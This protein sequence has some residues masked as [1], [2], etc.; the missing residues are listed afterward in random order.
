MFRQS[1]TATAAALALALL[2][3]GGNDDD[4]DD[5]GQKSRGVCR[6]AASGVRASARCPTGSL[7]SATTRSIRR[8]HRRRWHA[9][10][11]SRS[12]TPYPA[13][14]QQ[15][16][17]DADG[18]SSPRTVATISVWTGSWAFTRT[19]TAFSGSSIRR[20]RPKRPIR[21][22]PVRSA[23]CQA[24]GLEYEDQCAPKGHRPRCVDDDRVSAQ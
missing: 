5:K 9:E 19:P 4:S 23:A 1:R 7:S 8:R 21:R 17:R 6:A 2:A 13:G 11:R 18:S 10:R 3:C 24:G 16:C 15:T 12:T 20:S 14:L 22:I